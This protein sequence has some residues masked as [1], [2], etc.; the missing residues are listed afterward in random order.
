[1]DTVTIPEPVFWFQNLFAALAVGF[2][3]AAFIVAWIGNASRSWLQTTGTIVISEVHQISRKTKFFPRI[4]YE[5]QV[6]RKSFLSRILFIGHFIK[7][8][9][10]D[11]SR[12]MVTQYPKGLETKVY[13]NPTYPSLS[14]LEPGINK[15]II[16]NLITRMIICIICYS[17]LTPLVL[18]ELLNFLST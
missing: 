9:T 17:L 10:E 8:Y 2:A 15:G 18:K 7:T 1:M 5:Y 16:S 6:N 11:F 4:K 14:V 3:L 12:N 13:Y